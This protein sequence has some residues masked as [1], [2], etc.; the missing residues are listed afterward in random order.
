MRI[1]IEVQRI[2]RPRKHGMEVVAIELIRQLQQIDLQNEYILFTKPDL[3]DQCI[4]ESKNLKI[5]SIPAYSYADWEQYKLPN[6]VKKEKINF[7][8]CTCNT[9][10]LYINTPI[11]L[12]LHDIIFLE[13]MDFKG[14]S[15]QNF[16]NLY[17]RFLVPKIVKNCKIITTVSEFERNNIIEK[18]H[19]PEEKV[20]VVYNA[21]SPAFNN[22]YS[23]E[24]IEEFRKK[25]ALPQEFIMFLGNTATKKNTYNVIR[26]YL[27]FCINEKNEIP[28]V[29]LDY[30]KELVKKIV[31]EI[32]HPS[33]IKYFI[34]PGYI[35]HQ[36]M[37]LM[38]NAATLFLYPSLRESFGLPI[39]EAMACGVP[40][41][42]SNTSSM[43]E[44]AGDAAFLVNPYEHSSIAEGIAKLLSDKTLLLKYKE[45]G[46]QRAKVFT[47]H[48]SAEKLLSIY[49][50]MNC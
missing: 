22:N 38:Y 10:P 37:P 35:S 25:H 23:C 50:K 13:S 11:I 14:S 16:G 27:D 17:R 1:G 7:L 36:Q 5:K 31:D 32:R 44:I 4:Q 30:D 12:T 18:L 40:V 33:F 34:F 47:W 28:L 3:D 20:E 43:P 6:M 46:L 15:Y 49:K 29:L 9:A 41:I 8:H 2:F 48:A 24:Q 19:L 26:G 21:A 45:K 42:T 39:L